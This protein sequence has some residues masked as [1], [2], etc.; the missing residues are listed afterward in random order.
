MEKNFY[1]QEGLIKLGQIVRQARGKLSYRDFESLTGVSHATIR[2][3]ELGDVKTPD[4]ATLARIAPRT[5]YV[6]EELQAIAFQKPQGEVRQYRVAEDVMPIVMDLP[7]T[8]AARLAQMI[9]A[10]LVHLDNKS[11]LHSY[12]SK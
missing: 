9:I 8:E 1:T 4:F 2:R 10:K 3:L 6:V 11:A 12:N 5:P 7:A